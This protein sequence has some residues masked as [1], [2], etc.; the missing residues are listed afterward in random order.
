[1][2]EIELTEIDDNKGPSV[3]NSSSEQQNVNTWSGNGPTFIGNVLMPSLISFTVLTCFFLATSDD[4]SEGWVYVLFAAILSYSTFICYW[5]QVSS[6]MFLGFKLMILSVLYIM[7]FSWGIAI[8]N[9]NTSIDNWEDWKD[10]NEELGTSILIWLGI[11]SLCMIFIIVGSIVLLV[12]YMVCKPKEHR[13]N[14]DMIA[15]TI[16][17]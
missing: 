9:D 2:Q 17:A 12:L 4:R 3:P 5:I 6:R 10:D 13:T 11:Y 14:E 15:Q 8:V 1:M 16:D 7:M